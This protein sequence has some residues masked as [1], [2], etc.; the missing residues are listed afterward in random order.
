MGARYNVWTMEA[1][2]ID[3]CNAMNEYCGDRDGLVW[4]DSVAMSYKVP[5]EWQP[6]E[7]GMEVISRLHLSCVLLNPLTLDL[8]YL[9]QSYLRFF[10][11]F[12]FIFSSRAAQR[13][14]FFFFF[15]LY[16]G[17]G[18]GIGTV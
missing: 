16:S 3:V 5:S 4:L 7:D 11:F 8:E 9:N 14:F 6:R 1:S 10:F 18:S 2:G 15:S 12:F 13:F 17:K